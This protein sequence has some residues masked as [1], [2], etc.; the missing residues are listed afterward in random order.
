MNFR[1]LFLF[2]SFLFPFYCQAQFGEQR[3]ISMSLANPTDAKCIDMDG[4]GDLDIVVS[5]SKDD[6]IV[7]YENLGG[8]VFGDQ[9][10]ITT[11]TTNLVSLDLADV[12]NDGDIDL[13]S[14]STEDNKIVWYENLGN[15][16]FGSKQTITDNAVSPYSIYSADLDNDG[17]PDLI[18]ASVGDDKIAWYENVGNGGFGPEQVVSS[19]ADGAYSVYASD[20]DGDNKFDI[21]SASHNDGKIAWY[22]NLGSGAFSSENIITTN[23]SGAKS[24][25]SVDIDGDNDPDVLSASRYDDKIAW[26]ENLGGGNF[27]MQQVISTSLD[28]PSDVYSSD[29]DGD[30]DF[31]VLATSASNPNYDSIV[32]YENLGNG[33]FG[34]QRIINGNINNGASVI[35]AD[36]DG[37]GDFDVFGLSDHSNSSPHKLIWHENTG[38]AF[39]A[40]KI[41]DASY[42]FFS[43]HAS[44]LD[45]DGDQ[46]V[47]PGSYDNNKIIWYENQGNSLFKKN[48]AI[49]SISNG[50]NYVHT[51]DVDGDSD[52]DLLACHLGSI[53]W[54]E[55]LGNASFVFGNMLDSSATET[56]SL[57]A[58]DIDSDGDID[59]LAALYT[60]DI[61]SWYENLGNGVFG[62]RKTISSQVDGVYSVF[63]ADLDN[64]GDLDAQSASWFDNKIAWYENLGG[65]IFGTQQIISSGSIGPVSIYSADMNNDGK[66]DIL[67][68]SRGD[69]K[70][71][72]HENMGNGVFQSRQ[73]YSSSGS[74][75]SDVRAVDLDNDGD[76]DVLSA[77]NYQLSPIGEISWYENLGSGLFGFR[78]NFYDHINGT[79]YLYSSDLD[80]DGSIDVL[81]ASGADDRVAWY[82]NYF[83]S[84]YQIKG[85]VYYD[86]NE[87]GIKDGNDFGMSF[88]NVG[89]IPNALASYTNLSGDYFFATDTG[90]YVVSYSMDSLWNLTT[91]SIVYSLM[92]TDTTPTIDSVD[93]GFFPDTIITWLKPSLISGL[94]RC[95]T[96]VNVWVDVRNQGTTLPSG[97]ISLQLD[98]SINYVSSDIIPDSIVGPRVFWSYDSLYFYSSEQ[99]KVQVQMPG[100]F[101]IGDTLQSTISVFEIDNGNM[102]YSNVDTL[103]Q[104][105]ICAYD[106]NDKAVEP[107]GEGIKGYV[108]EETVLEYLIRFQNTGNDT[109]ISIQIR[110]QLDENLNWDSFLPISSSHDFLV[111]IDGNGE[112]VFKFD[113][114]FLPDSTTN[115]FES[116][117]YVK[118]SVRIKGGLAPN[119]PI[120][121]T[122]HIYFDSNP[123]IQTNTVLNT[124]ECFEIIH[125]IIEYNSPYL[126]TPFLTDHT[127]QWYY[128]GSPIIGQTMDTIFPLLSGAYSVEIRDTN[129]CL[130][131]SQ[132]YLFVNVDM[133]EIEPLQIAVY[134]NPFSKNLSVKSA[135]RNLQIRVYNNIGKVVLYKEN[136]SYIEQI[137]T[138]RWSA[139]NYIV[140]IISTEGVFHQKK[141]IKY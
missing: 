103:N 121:N 35:A 138:D 68:A 73:I 6:K 32:W 85:E 87:N 66:V 22:K 111:T 109:A 26:Y 107:K 141:V 38:G 50:A 108:E 129:S 94:P 51:A 2:G 78:Q 54:Y 105:L 125:P 91:D 4:D 71:E 99:F 47:I 48:I 9:Q 72:W 136:V 110:D 117:G 89:L 23:A 61:I 30:G 56:K 130:S 7:W 67:S 75:A 131:R 133:V 82:K 20:I 79:C 74:I 1:K 115:F 14:A 126:S 98:D 18:S 60:E 123:Y 137:N 81:S 76:L 62:L 36:L 13:F 77:S 41:I 5:S 42:S 104:V 16:N 139:G 57:Y 86:G 25:Y 95:N 63:L 46:D 135:E 11:S 17:D 44:D 12:D 37:D 100:V 80:N 64:D 101:S 93:F 21:L 33:I 55:N 52:I 8:G 83:T 40:E 29:L 113:S 140:Q 65:G 132:E 88:V 59:I 70:I 39:G 45:N 49:D 134:P 53:V 96:V 120:L 10:I 58:G 128:N 19:V 34:S 84:P 15:N 116:Q 124:V 69:G 97:V 127:F 27:G 3:D 112:A 31:D 106:P 118:Y 43:V 122:A 90:S 28:E 24:V 114:I 92:L 102:V 119:T